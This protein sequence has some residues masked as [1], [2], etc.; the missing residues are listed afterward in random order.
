VKVQNTKELGR[1]QADVKRQ[2]AQA[3]PRVQE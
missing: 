2:Q 1:V 3:G